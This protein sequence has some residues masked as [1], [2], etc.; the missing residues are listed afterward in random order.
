MQHILPGGLQ[1]IHHYG[2]LASPCGDKRAQARA[3]LHMPEL[4]PQTLEDA[5]AFMHR[6]SHVQI[7][8]CPQCKS[9]TLQ[10]IQTLAGS[11]HLPEP[12]TC[13]ERRPPATPP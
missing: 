2:L 13:C 3:A 10:V 12:R 8:Q 11:K 7:M 9:G 1:R 5:V 4:R 6:V